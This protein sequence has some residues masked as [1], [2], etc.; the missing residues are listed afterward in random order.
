MGGRCF[1]LS[2]DKHGNWA[3]SK[4][5]NHLKNDHALTSGAVYVKVE[6]KNQVSKPH[7]RSL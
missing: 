1:K 4:A 5:V 3:T 7:R 6:E 2:K